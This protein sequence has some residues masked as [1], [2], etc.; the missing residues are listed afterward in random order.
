M[1]NVVIIGSNLVGSAYGLKKLSISQRRILDIPA[2]SPKKDAIFT[3]LTPPNFL[4]FF[5]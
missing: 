5:V 3:I 4:S 2:I 1:K